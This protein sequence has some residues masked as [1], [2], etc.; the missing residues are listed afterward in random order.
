[1]SKSCWP[2]PDSAPHGWGRGV[3]VGVILLI[4]HCCGSHQYLFFFNP[5][6][7]HSRGVLWETR[8]EVQSPNFL[9]LYGCPKS[10]IFGSLKY[11]LL[12]QSVPRMHRA[13]GPVTVGRVCHLF[14]ARVTSASSTVMCWDP[15][16]TPEI[17]MGFAPQYLD[18]I[19]V[20]CT[21]VS[22]KAQYSC[23]SDEP[24]P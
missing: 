3:L 23:E 2:L 24:R 12:R 1:M 16:V 10:L 19:K 7:P 13:S 17:E 8:Q 4:L 18:G 15:P 22:T 6:P 9:C 20:H 5:Q 14:P 21:L 11:P